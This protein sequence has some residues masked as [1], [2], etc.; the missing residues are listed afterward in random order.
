DDSDTVFRRV[1]SATLPDTVFV[2]PGRH[3]DQYIA[4]NGGRI[5]VGDTRA[6]I[7]GSNSGA[8]FVYDYQGAYPGV[9]WVHTGTLT[10]LDTDEFDQFGAAVDLTDS[11]AVVGAASGHPSGFDGAVYVFRRQPDSG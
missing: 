5:V 3:L 9:A 10:V 6:D 4:A 11:L 7:T 2:P 8:A 1:G